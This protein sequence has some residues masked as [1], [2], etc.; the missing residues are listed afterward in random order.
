M[1][2]VAIF[3]TIALGY[4]LSFPL[5]TS[6]QTLQN[7]DTAPNDSFEES[8]TI[9]PGVTRIFGNIEV[10]PVPD[11]D[12]VAA[13]TIERGEVNRFTVSNLP[14]STP[15][16]AWM[17]IENSS[18][19][20]SLGLFDASDNL[21]RTA[22][23][24]SPSGNYAPAMRGTVPASGTLRFKV[25]GS[26]D[27]NFDGAEEYYDNFGNEV[28]GEPHYAEGE[29]TFSVVTGET[30]IQGD[31]DFFTLTN[32]TPGDIFSVSAFLSEY[33]VRLAW[34][35]DNGS[36]V[37]T[38][39]YSDLTYTEAISGIVPA[40]GNINIAVSGY[41]DYDFTGNHS[42]PGEYLLKVSTQSVN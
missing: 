9:N 11:A 38:S 27:Y 29:Y 2:R 20:A 10:P 15:F 24:V 12:Y 33:G 4:T 22:Y 23:E 3:S 17:D 19:S 13:E 8:I 1:K 34:F 21:I 26:S 7:I 31:I 41:D 28:P 42:N 18:M 30:D 14:P 36:M 16:F 25:T 39:S 6:A 35:A 37:S 5:S 40:S 32:L